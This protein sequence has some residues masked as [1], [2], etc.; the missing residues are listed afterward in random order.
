MCFLYTRFYACGHG[1][2]GFRDECMRHRTGSTC[3]E[4]HKDEGF[5]SA[6]PIC[7]LSYA[8]MGKQQEHLNSSDKQKQQPSTSDKHEEDPDTCDKK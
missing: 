2:T 4:I 6:C 7:S 1:L 5:M 8:A 3:V